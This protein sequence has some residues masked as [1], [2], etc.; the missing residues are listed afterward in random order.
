MR[1]SARISLLVLLT[2]VVAVC[3]APAAQAAE[4][5]VKEDSF[6]AGTCINSS[7][8]YES[9][10]GKPSEAFTQA[11]GHPQFGLTVFELNQTGGKPYGGPLKRVRVDVPPG[12]AA[13]PEALPKCSVALFEANACPAASEV[14]KN[15]LTVGSIIGPKEAEG[16]VYNLEQPTGPNGVPLLFGIWVN[17]VE[18]IKGA[19]NEHVL[20]VGHVS[21]AKEKVLEERGIP[22]GDYHEWFEIDNISKTKEGAELTPAMRSKLI[23]NGRAGVGNFLTLPSVCSKT[24]TSYIE[25]A[26]WNGERD[27]FHKADVTNTPLG[28]EGCDGNPPFKPVPFAPT[29]EVQPETTQSDLPDGATTEVKV[30]QYTGTTEVNTADIKDVHVTLAEGLTLNPSAAR[31]LETCSPTQIGIGT[32]AP[33][34][35]PTASKLGTVLIESDL[36][37]P[38]TGSV[39]LGNP[40]GGPI[41]E[42]PFTIY[43]ALTSIYGVQVR[44]NGTVNVNPSTGRLEATFTENPQLPF[45]KLVLKLN[46]GPQAPLANPLACGTSTTESLFTPYTGLAAALSSTPF[47]TSGCLS[48]IPFALTQS[49]Q[50]GSAA[51]GAN[52][53][54]TF[55]L[56]RSDG[57]QYL[58]QVS[59]LL[60]AGLIGTIP[61][62]PLCGEPQA[63]QG[64]CPAAS[65]IGTASAQ[66][67]SGPEPFTFTGPVYLTGPYNGA[68]FGLSIPVGVVAGP[69]DFGTVVNRAAINV[70][71]Y[72]ARV[73][74]TGGPPTIVKG[75]PVRLKGLTVSVNRANFL[76]NPTN[77]G[78]LATESTLTSTFGATQGV[79]TPFQVSSCDALPF[80]PTFTAS[81]SANPTKANGASLDVQM[82]QAARQANIRS[83][84]TQLPKQLVSR[85]TTL[86]QACPEATYAANPYSCPDG[87]NVGTA[88]AVTPVLP[89]S[90]SGPAYLVSHGGAAFPDLDILLEGSGV[91]TILVGKT[92]I[93]KGITTTTFASIPDVPV[94]SFA[95]SLPM[96]PHSA[97]AANG[98]ICGEAL[99]MPTTITAQ[100]GAQIKQDTKLAIAG[101][102]SS[103]ARR[104]LKILKRKVSRKAVTLRLRTCTA[105]RL[106]ARGSKL[107]TSAR[108]LRKASTL[109][110]KVPLTR[111]GVKALHS[112]R[113]L[114]IRVRVVFVPA[115][116]GLAHSSASTSVAFKR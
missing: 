53:S 93:S 70:D 77:C 66:A 116:R 58:A 104:C 40:T 72:T 68:P 60:P 99:E 43:L 67:G 107:K 101:C 3:S 55:S 15:Q 105:G 71:P 28:V 110:L 37:L 35:C 73:S 108:K 8:T 103:S 61:S 46:G 69:F 7:C 64:T 42:P 22:S 109:N 49:A 52:T 56:S 18:K 39:F 87:A 32:E 63:Q 85:L 91:R 34:T 112:H 94:S 5:G 25:V 29:A 9:V 80:S 44:L 76:I 50:N 92:N 20:L 47:T 48:P 38:L 114:K 88:T 115:Q 84:V 45:S 57:Q 14:G 79:S 13:N 33:V 62:V 19:L 26:S 21:W 65:Q 81:T 95:L 1:V 82:T 16:P 4:F 24:T 30:T 10:I 41:T 96:G 83:V 97:L 75:V 6:E 86:Q 2:G 54:Y 90:L 102:R 23:F 89:G 17:T 59:T 27:A 51:A 31:G 11:A 74:A 111:R 36:P 12:L 78:L 100:N 98:T 113:R 106:T